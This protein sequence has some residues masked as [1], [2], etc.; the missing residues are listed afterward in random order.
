M[1]EHEVLVPIGREEIPFHGHTITAVKLED[2]RIAVIFNW[3]C[4]A[5][6]LD[7][8]G[9]TQRIERTPSIASELI[10]VRTLTKRGAMR[11]MQALTLRGFPTW[12][13]GINPSEVEGNTPEEAERVQQMIIAYQVEAVDVL[14]NHF[15]KKGYLALPESRAVVLAEPAKPIQ[16]QLDAFDDTWIEYYEQMARWHHWRKDMQTWKESTDTRLQEVEHKQDTMEVRMEG[17]EAM[18]GLIPE[19]LE[20]LGPETLT[21]AHQRQV[22]V[23]VKQLSQAAGKHPNTIYEDLKTAFQKPRYQ[24]LLEDEWLQVE[25]WFKVQIERAKKRGK[26]IEHQPSLFYDLQ[27]DQGK[28]TFRD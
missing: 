10:R 17:V 27:D 4:E 22:Q 26:G 18:T 6:R 25:N 2:G 13:L 8:Q 28:E 9:Q 3:V 16:P 12:I 1:Q 14:Y 21:P 7:P 20:R 5:L 15:A 19:I 11:P 23:Y 24:D